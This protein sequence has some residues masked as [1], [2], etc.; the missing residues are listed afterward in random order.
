MVFM[1]SLRV[2]SPGETKNRRNRKKISNN[3]NVPGGGGDASWR[4]IKT[5]FVNNDDAYPVIVQC[6]EYAFGAHDIC[7]IIS[8]IIIN[9][10][11]WEVVAG[12]VDHDR[13]KMST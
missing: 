3:K 4:L 9:A 7:V 12:A 1:F 8:L 2:V 11:V 10:V 13:K 5:I 6:N